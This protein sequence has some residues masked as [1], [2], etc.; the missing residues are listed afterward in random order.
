LI[1]TFHL[2]HRRKGPA[3]C[4]QQFRQCTIQKRSHMLR[5]LFQEDQL[6]RELMA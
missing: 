2:W 3:N 4:L 6:L 1:G 5:L